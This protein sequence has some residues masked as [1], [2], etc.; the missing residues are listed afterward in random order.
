MNLSN[1]KIKVLKSIVFIYNFLESPKAMKPLYFRL[2]Q[3]IKGSGDYINVYFPK[4]Y[5]Y[6]EED[7]SKKYLFIINRNTSK[8]ILKNLHKH[9]F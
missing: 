2:T 6:W 5:N 4:T 7:V 3:I 1:G 9:V 8:L